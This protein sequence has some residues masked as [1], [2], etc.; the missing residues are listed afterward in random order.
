[1]ECKISH[2]S[3]YI[4]QRQ[5]RGA[6]VFSKKEA[7][8]ALGIS[9]NAFRKSVM[10]LSAKGMVAYIKKGLYMIIPNEYY[11]SKAIPCEWYIN[12]LMAHL[13]RP[14]YVGL[15]SAAALHGSAHQAPQLFQVV[16]DEHI[17]PLLSPRLRIKFYYSKNINLTPTQKVKT[18]AGYISVSTPEG[19]AFDLIR[20]LHQSG[21]INHVATVL[22]E[23]AEVI[24]GAELAEIA[25]RFSLHY[26]QRLGYLLDFAGFSSLTEKLYCHIK[27]YSLHYV[28]LRPDWPYH[29]VDKD[30]KWHILINEVIDL[31]I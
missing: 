11:Y 21:H 8:I 25:K 2:L 19:T 7:L 9:E 12:Q 16:T 26:C 31:D 10:R 30:P 15:L 6:C 4:R 5:A 29:D 28:P 1:M 17:R 14:Y 3:D 27:S 22:S 13:K 18:P 23:L 24:N 20:Y